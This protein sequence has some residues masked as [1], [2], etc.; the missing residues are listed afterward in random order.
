MTTLRTPSLLTPSVSKASVPVP[1]ILSGLVLL[2][3][4]AAAATPWLLAPTDPFAVDLTAILKPPSIEHIFGTDQSG[5]DVFTRV[6]HGARESLLIGLGATGLALSV[7]IVLGAAAGLGNK[8]VDTIISRLLD[9]FFSFPVLLFALLFVVVAGPGVATQIVA[10]GLGT[11]PGYAR[12]I[13][14][15]VQS[16]RRSG[17]VEAAL[18]LG[19]PSGRIFRQ[20]ILPNA[21]RPLVAVVTLSIGQ[22]IV[23][24]SG[25][26]FLGL[27]VAPPSAEWGALLDAGRMYVTSAW[28]LEIFPGLAIVL[29]ALAA[30][31]L[32][33]YLQRRLEGRND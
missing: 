7:A 13:R 30:T 6:V 32:G 10:V 31:T 19:H 23:W 11:A 12:M 25:L 27:G 20:H 1:A 9:V 22:S 15:Q 24:A 5:R 17:Y 29:V 26:A 3:A 18:A 21:L 2:W 8:V 4:V 16:V 33:S 14:G 28:W